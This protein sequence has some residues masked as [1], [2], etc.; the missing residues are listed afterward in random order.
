MSTGTHRNA[1][2]TRR[3][4]SQ[5]VAA[6]T[7]AIDEIIRLH[8]HLG[9]FVLRHVGG[10]ECTLELRLIGPTIPRDPDDIALG[11]V[12]GVLFLIDRQTDIALGYPDFH[13]DLVPGRPGEERATEAGV[14]PHLISRAVRRG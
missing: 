13:V 3:M 14:Q 10:E 8:A 7:E 6:G 1:E 2:R 5:R 11:T 9:N 12:G 4:G